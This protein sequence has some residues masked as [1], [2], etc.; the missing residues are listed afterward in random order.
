M[1]TVYAESS[2]VLRWLLGTAGAPVLQDVLGSARV[3]VSS[4]LTSTEVARTLRRLV[5]T[6]VMEP[7]VGDASWA[8]YSAA[9]AHWHLYGV[10]DAVLARA[11]QPFPQEP[12]RTPDAIH[13]ATAALFALEVTPPT[14]LSVDQQLRANAQGLGMSVMPPLP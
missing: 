9:I 14:I 6:G 5:A 11:S 4:S 3:V 12:V 1:T 7:Q 10:T 8:R 2:A 13:L